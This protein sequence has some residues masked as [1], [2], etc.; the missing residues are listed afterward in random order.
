MISVPNL[1]L[2]KCN[3]T[4]EEALIVTSLQLTV[5]TDDLACSVEAIVALSYCDANLQHGHVYTG[6]IV[7]SH[8]ITSHPGNAL[9]IWSICP[10]LGMSRHSSHDGSTCSGLIIRCWKLTCM[11]HPHA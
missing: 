3:L 8:K 11:R 5:I 2:A 4:S 7:L 9:I 10:L 6:Y 1:L